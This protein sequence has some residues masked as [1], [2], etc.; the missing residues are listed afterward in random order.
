MQRL[1]YVFNK[2]EFSIKDKLKLSDVLVS[3]VLNYSS[4]V[5]IYFESKDIEN[6]HLN[7]LRKLLCVN[8]STNL[9]GLL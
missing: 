5:S 3:P 2:Y 8:K 7:C 6:V 4:E 1:F 9:Y